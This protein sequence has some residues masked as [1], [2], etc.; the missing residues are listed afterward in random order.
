MIIGTLFKVL[1]DVESKNVI[2]E[3]LKVAENFI[4]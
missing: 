2:S 4:Y 3:Y 1:Y